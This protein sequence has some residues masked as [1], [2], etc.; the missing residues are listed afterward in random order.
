MGDNLLLNK[1]QV[2]SNA[3]KTTLQLKTLISAFF[4]FLAIFASTIVSFGQNTHFS[5][6]WSTPADEC[7]TDAIELSDGGYIIAA[8]TGDYSTYTYQ[9]LFIRLNANGDTVKTK[10]FT[11]PDG[12]CFLYDLVKSDDSTFFGI[13]RF[14]RSA[15]EVDLWIL[16][17]NAD[18]DTLWTKHFITGFQ[19]LYS[20]NGFIDSYQHL[21]LYGDGG[22]SNNENIYIYKLTLAGDSV[23]ARYYPTW[24]LPVQSMTEK[25]N[26][27]GYLMAVVGTYDSTGSSFGQLLSFDYELNIAKI[28]SIPRQ[29][30]MYYNLKESTNALYLTGK[31]NYVN[32][33]PR[34]DRLGILKLDTSFNVLSEFY[35]GPEDT[36]SYPAYLHCLDFID[37]TRIYYGGTVNYGLG[38][39]A[40]IPS[41]YILGKFN[42]DL[43]LAWQKYY[44]GE[45]YFNLW[46]LTASADG[47]CLL[48]GSSYDY[49]TPD[50][51]RDMVIIKVDSNGVYTGIEPTQTKLFDAIVYPNPGSGYLVI[52]SGPQISG[53]QFR[54]TSMEGKL[55]KS[56]TLTCLK[57]TVNTQFLEAGT[58]VWQIFYNNRVIENGK[59]IRL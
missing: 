12:D 29:L 10:T 2:K 39:F 5:F 37:T 33:Y 52:E 1:L 26:N 55:V 59:W 19:N 4:W 56:E 48:M 50:I 58:Y 3:F 32:S 17:M 30:V 51:E 57:T 27:A 20:F 15:N 24:T 42:S 44:G 40:P 41:W 43:T 25:N 23:K 22:G 34:T 7:P 46:A 18:L 35:L 14:R 11:N 6:T 53:A 47:G 28:D 21:I 36:I 49:S 8:K 13:G 16:K 45:K 9:T 54:L 38:E 31:R